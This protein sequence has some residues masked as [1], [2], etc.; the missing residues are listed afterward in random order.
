MID[1]ICKMKTDIVKQARTEIDE[2]GIERMD[3][4]RIG[5][6][7]DMVKDLA[8]AEEKYWKGQYYRNLVTEAMEARF[9]GA[10]TL[11]KQGVSARMIE[12][13]DLV[14]Q[15]GMKYQGLSPEEKMAMKSR[16]LMKLSS[17]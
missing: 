7:V 5:E 10:S 15:L 16:V 9:G 17:M 14:D 2:R 3:V 13:D 1:M 12:H 8:E 6:M 4:D 11:P